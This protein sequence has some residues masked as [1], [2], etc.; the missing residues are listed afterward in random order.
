MLKLLLRHHGAQLLL[1]TTCFAVLYVWLQLLCCQVRKASFIRH[2]QLLGVHGQPRQL[3]FFEVRGNSCQ[4]AHGSSMCACG[5][6]WWGSKC[7]FLSE[8]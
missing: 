1:C 8:C 5:Q 6:A 7:L 2:W 4:P 3:Q